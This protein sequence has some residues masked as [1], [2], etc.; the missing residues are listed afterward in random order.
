[1]QRSKSMYLLC[2]PSLAGKS[3]A[4]ARIAQE[5]QAVVISADEINHERGL[6]FGAEGLPQS[7][8]AETLEMM[9]G[10]IRE[11]ATKSHSIIIDDTLCFRWLRD[12]FRNEAQA[13]GLKPYLLLLSVT[14]EELQ[15]RHT[16][17][18]L[19]GQRPTLSMPQLL[20]HFESFEWPSSDEAATDI[21][22]PEHLTTWLHT[23][24]GDGSIMA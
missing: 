2:G 20:E 17:L 16:A 24:L 6:P 21:S 7:V 14:K 18:S 4:C 19:S 15:A 22:V 23:R 10:R 13:N 1:M 11:H 9:L 3:T 5:L 8:W 12:R